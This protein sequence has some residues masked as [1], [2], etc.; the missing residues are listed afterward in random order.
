[1]PPLEK[2]N[3]VFYAERYSRESQ[4]LFKKAVISGRHAVKL[5]LGVYRHQDY[6]LFVPADNSSIDP[7][8]CLVE[9]AKAISAPN[10]DE[11]YMVFDE[12]NPCAQEQS[13]P[14]SYIILQTGNNNLNQTE[15]R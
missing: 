3:G 2:F 7:N 8:E 4:E 1:M 13:L 9:M 5:C 10:R 14:A 6:R 11:E 15:S 12:F